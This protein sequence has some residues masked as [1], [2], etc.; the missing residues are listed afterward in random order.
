[1]FECGLQISISTNLE[2]V[3]NAHFLEMKKLL[4]SYLHCQIHSSIIYN[5]Q[6]ME[7]ILSVHQYNEYYSAIRRGEMLSSVTTWMNVL[8]EINQ[9]QKTN[10]TWSH[11]YIKNLKKKKP[12]PNSEKQIR[13]VATEAEA[14]TRGTGWG[15]QKV[16][17]S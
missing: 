4:E 5:G 16:H 7:I 2:S 17:T 11:L 15:G 8:S 1:M 12:Q 14:N 6:D 13:F 9:R 10:T 3:R